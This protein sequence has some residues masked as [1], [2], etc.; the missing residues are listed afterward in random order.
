MN[1]FNE[2]SINLGQ[3]WSFNCLDDRGVVQDGLGWLLRDVSGPLE[4]R[5]D[6]RGLVS[7]QKCRDVE[8]LKI[9]LVIKLG[10]LISSTF[11]HQDLQ[12]LQVPRG[13]TALLPYN[14]WMLSCAG[15]GES[16]L[17]STELSKR[18]S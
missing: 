17:F 7:A 16:G 4:I 18:D 12:F 2:I 15:R 14:K 3:I 11:I 13:G 8:D 1:F 10:V 9:L 5:N 6:L